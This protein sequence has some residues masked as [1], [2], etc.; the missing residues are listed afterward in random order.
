MKPILNILL[1]ITLIICNNSFGQCADSSDATLPETK[2]WIENKIKNHGGRNLPPTKYHV[3]F[4]E[5]KLIITEIGLDKN[6]ELKDSVSRFEIE[7]KD[8]DVKNLKIREIGKNDRFGISLNPINGKSIMKSESLG[9]IT[10]IGFEIILQA[11]NENLDKRLVKAIAHAV[12][13]AGGN[14]QNSTKQT[15]KF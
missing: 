2:E 15:E 12:C 9:N 8:I 7:L 6:F 14:N 11:E 5:N 10:G 3:K 13:L 1:F 4:K